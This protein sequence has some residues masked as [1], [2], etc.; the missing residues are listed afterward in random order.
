MA[1]CA[2]ALTAT[3]TTAALTD[4][5]TV[6][7]AVTVVAVDAAVV[8]GDRVV[9]AVEAAAIAVVRHT[10]FLRVVLARRFRH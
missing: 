8:V 3:T 10:R 2:A 6:T 5:V 1:P 9:A 7:L 4:T